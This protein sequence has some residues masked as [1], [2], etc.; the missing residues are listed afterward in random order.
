LIEKQGV[1][2]GRIRPLTSHKGSP[3]LTPSI[4]KESSV[5]TEQGAFPRHV[6]GQVAEPDGRPRG[7]PDAG[8]EGLP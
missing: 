1:R 6:S 8:G 7:D 4:A 3:G 5:F 2:M